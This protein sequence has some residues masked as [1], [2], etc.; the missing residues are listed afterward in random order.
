MKTKNLNAVVIGGTGVVGRELILQLAQADHIK[1]IVSLT[2]RRVNYDLNKVTNKVIEF[3]NLD[4]FKTHFRGDLF[5]SCLGTTKKIA[6]SVMAQRR[7]DL[8][9]QLE[10]AAQA[11]QQGVQHCLL[12]S[13]SGANRHSWLAYPKM[14][15]ELEY[16]VKQLEFARLTIL[17][18]SLLLGHRDERRTGED[19]AAVVLPLLTKLPGL[20]KAR[21]ISGVE[22]ARRLVAESRESEPGLTTLTLDQIFVE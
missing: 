18:P 21:P 20:G 6:G 14:K 19:L 7:V 13:S 12:V 8:D 17:Q 11:K 15:G 22:V 3:E 5:F 16:A 1:E 4:A 10:C 9:Y 2:R